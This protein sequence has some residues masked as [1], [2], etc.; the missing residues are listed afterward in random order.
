MLPKLARDQDTGL[1]TQDAFRELLEAFSARAWQRNI[2]LTLA[3]VEVG[4][5]DE[6][7]VQIRDLLE[8]VL[9]KSDTVGR[10]DTRCLAVLLPCCGGDDMQSVG[11]RI[12]QAMRDGLMLCVGLADRPARSTGSEEISLRA[13]QALQEARESEA[14]L[15]ALA[16]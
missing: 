14:R 2:P 12:Q 3:I 11:S 10:F 1:L 9:R 15:A 8:Q 4:E 13:L 16:A 6:R 5:D 7:T